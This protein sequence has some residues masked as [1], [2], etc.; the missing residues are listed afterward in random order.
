MPP[1]EPGVLAPLLPELGSLFVL[2]FVLLVLP[3]VSCP[4]EL[5]ES[6]TILP[7]SM[8]KLMVPPISIP[9]WPPMTACSTMAEM[10]SARPLGGPPPP[11][12]PSAWTWIVAVASA[13]NPPRLKWNGPVENPE[14]DVE[15]LVEV[16][17]C[18]G[19][20]VDVVD[21]VEVELLVVV[22]VLVDELVL[23]PDAWSGDAAAAGGVSI[24]SILSITTFAFLIISLAILSL[25]RGLD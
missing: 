6:G 23:L 2:V 14:F 4:P 22:V 21:V 12:P 3:A 13:G 15:V 16:D 11:A 17:L 19:A 9:P 10:A 25:T 1:G 7:F 5:P 8:R 20:L 18:S 24:P